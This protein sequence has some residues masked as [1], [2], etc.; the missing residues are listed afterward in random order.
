MKKPNLE[1]RK[2]LLHYLHFFDEYKKYQSCN[3]LLLTK[4]QVLGSFQETRVFKAFTPSVS[5][6]G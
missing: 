2:I 3:F 6:F 5:E 4:L 1:S